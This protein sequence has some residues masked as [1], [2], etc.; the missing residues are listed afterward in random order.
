MATSVVTRAR[1]WRFECPEC[2]FG[3]REHGRLIEM[4]EVHCEICLGEDRV[5]RLRMWPADDDA[6]RPPELG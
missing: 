3:D 2:G 1:L 5:I 4:H 6:D